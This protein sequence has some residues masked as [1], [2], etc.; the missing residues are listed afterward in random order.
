MYGHQFYQGR[1]APPPDAI[2]NPSGLKA[3]SAAV[4]MVFLAGLWFVTKKPEVPESDPH[5]IR[6]PSRRLSTID[7]PPAQL[8]VNYQAATIDSPAVEP[9]DRSRKRLGQPVSI[10]GTSEQANLSPSNESPTSREDTSSVS[11]V[12][13]PKDTMNR[14]AETSSMTLEGSSVTSMDV[15]PDTLVHAYWNPFLER[16]LRIPEGYEA[17]AAMDLTAWHKKRT[18]PVEWSRLLAEGKLSRI[19]PRGGLRE[20][21]CPAWETHQPLLLLDP[22]TGKTVQVTPDLPARNVKPSCDVQF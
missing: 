11:L 5:P 4:G 13:K 15:A 19:I 21:F 14:K 22:Y 7:N 16:W 20:R 1:D 12:A 9:P 17:P 2:Y 10:D 6:K 3:E 18:D 8:S